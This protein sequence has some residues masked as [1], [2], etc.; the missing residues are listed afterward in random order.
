[1]KSTVCFVCGARSLNVDRQA[2]LTL[3]AG[4]TSNRKIIDA[5]SSNGDL[6][7][8]MCQVH[9]RSNTQG[10]HAW[11]DTTCHIVACAHARYSLRQEH[12]ACEVGFMQA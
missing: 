9:I 4:C 3:L 1:M 12:D 2:K 10:S 6:Q 11:Q 5:A 8:W 7:R